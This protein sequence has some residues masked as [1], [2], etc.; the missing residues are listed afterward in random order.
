LTV[1]NPTILVAQKGVASDYIVSYHETLA[2]ANVG[3]E[4]IVQVYI[5]IVVR[6]HSLFMLE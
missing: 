5:I 6:L 1:Q 2:A 4:V 3:S